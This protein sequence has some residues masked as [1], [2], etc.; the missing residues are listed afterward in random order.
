MES[1]VPARGVWAILDGSGSADDASNSTINHTVDGVNLRMRL[2][3]WEIKELR[4]RIWRMTS[5]VKQLKKVNNGIV[6]GLKAAKSEF[7]RLRKAEGDVRR[8]KSTKVV[9]N[10]L[11]MVK[12]L[13]TENIGI[14]VSKLTVQDGRWERL[15]LKNVLQLGIVI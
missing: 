14:E 15:M 3:A 12:D 1:P 4:M 10:N 8:N 11:R 7:R 13:V 9:K 5:Y 6:V 2:K